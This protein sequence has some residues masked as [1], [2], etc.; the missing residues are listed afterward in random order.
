MSRLFRTLGVSLCAALLAVLS[1]HGIQEGRHQLGHTL[2]WPAVS[3]DT[4]HHADAVDIDHGALH[5]HVAPE[6]SGSGLDLDE[7]TDNDGNAGRPTG[8]HHSSG[9]DHTAIPA[10][11]RDLS[12]LVAGRAVLLQPALDGAMPAHDADGPEYPPKRTRTVI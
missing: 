2:D 9:G 1:L 10:T 12:L 6:A 4:G 8:H 7:N 11:G 5:V 3:I